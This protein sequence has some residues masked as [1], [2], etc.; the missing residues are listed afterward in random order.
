MT[1]TLYDTETVSSG[2][3]RW[4]QV[5]ITYRQL[6][7]WAWQG[8]LR[9]D[10]AHPGSG[11]SRRWPASE[12]A[13]AARMVRLVNAGLTPEAASRAARASGPV[14]L[15]PGIWAACGEPDEAAVA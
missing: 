10:E 12:I 1:D 13:V 6:N 2:D 15:A 14:E 8:Y 5:G 3:L 11:Y 9:P 4:A 7:W